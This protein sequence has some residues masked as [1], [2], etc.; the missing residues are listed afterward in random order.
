MARTKNAKRARVEGQS[1]S[2]ARLVASSHYMAR[3]MLSP[4]ALNNHVEKFKSRAIVLPM[5]VYSTLNYVVPES[6]EE[7]E[8]V[9]M[10]LIE[11][12]LGSWHYKVTLEQLAE[13]WNLV[14]HG[15]KFTGG[16]PTDEEWGEYER[17]ISLQS[18]QYE[19]PHMDAREKSI[20]LSNVAKI[21]DSTL[22]QI[23]KDLN[24][25]EPQ[26]QGQAQDPEVQAQ[27]QESPPPPP[28]SPTMRDL[29][30]ELRNI[31]LYIEGQFAEIRQH[32]DR[33]ILV[34]K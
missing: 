23:E 34:M 28:P 26:V 8:E 9:I 10:S 16:I 21:D 30:D 11:F 6:D 7:N 25:Q 14:Y 33:Q 3:W 13:Q 19:D 15:G 18:L 20:V 22:R 24:A 29:M 4:K 2:S 31:R 27:S 1:S 17:L 5:A 12:D 32:Q